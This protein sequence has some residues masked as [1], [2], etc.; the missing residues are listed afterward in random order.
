VGRKRI[1]KEEIK[2]NISIGL[3]KWIIEEIDKITSNRSEY[4][5]KLVKND[6]NRQ[7]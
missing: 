6:L 4:I 2:V 5:E 1:E 3:K 7:K